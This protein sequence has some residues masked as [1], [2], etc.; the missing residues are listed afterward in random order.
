[1]D[2]LFIP[3]GCKIEGEAVAVVNDGDIVIENEMTPRSLVSREGGVKYCP[4]AA[5]V[6]CDNLAAEQG[7][8]EIEA[9]TY[10]GREILAQSAHLKADRFELETL[11]VAGELFLE[12]QTVELD[13]CRAGRLEIKT[14]ELKAKLIESDGEVNIV[15]DNAK[16]E[17]IVAK[18]VVVKGALTCHRIVAEE[19]VV[20]ES[21]RVSIKYLDAPAF[22]AAP[23]VAGIVVIANSEEVKAEGVRGFLHPSELDL[24]A[25]EGG[26]IPSIDLGQVERVA[27]ET[28]PP[29]A[30]EEAAAIETQPL[31]GEP[32]EG[33]FAEVG[34]DASP[35]PDT[36]EAPAGPDQPA[37][38]DA[39]YDV[40]APGGEAAD[41]DESGL[42][43]VASDEED[44]DTY[45][46][47][48][49]IAAAE[50]VQSAS[51]EAS[52]T[53]TEEL[54][55]IETVETLDELEP[56]PAADSAWPSG[57]E[58]EGDAAPDMTPPP[59]PEETPMGYGAQNTPQLGEEMDNTEELDD[60]S[61]P[62][63]SGLEEERGEP[64]ELDPQSFDADDGGLEDEEIESVDSFDLSEIGDEEND[65]EELSAEDL[66]SME[67]TAEEDAVLEPLGEEPAALTESLSPEESLSRELIHILDQVKAYFPEDNYPNFLNQLTRYVADHRFSL[68][69]KERNK[70][71]VLASFE[72]LGHPEIDTLA[73]AF[74]AKVDEYHQQ[75]LG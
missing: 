33:A 2:K 38:E 60:D 34:E 59:F 13:S 72:K 48:Q 75:M 54:D 42:I 20:A 17:K 66:H 23:E 29:G 51:M 6:H 19:T 10:R 22:H 50:Q 4:Q 25:E 40:A 58:S 21:G 7:L 62:E 57:P 44:T 11:R 43:S 27:R 41:E 39:G 71:A 55:E 36:A 45:S 69:A 28:P 67:E 24:L 65:A 8:V 73:S 64:L 1:M 26:G 49:I 74:F 18:K 56:I 63:I 52:E 16:I 37:E 3:K 15:A 47:S 35:A 46:V 14:G 70:E 30:P 32:E 31:D 5:E 53:P 61:L 9:Q 12:A 68:F